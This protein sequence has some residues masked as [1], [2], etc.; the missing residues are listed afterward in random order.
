MTYPQDRHQKARNKTLLRGVLL[1]TPSDSSDDWLTSYADLVTLLM[2]FF[3]LLVSISAIDASKYE[4]IAKSFSAGSEVHPPQ[5]NLNELY[6]ELTMMLREENLTGRVEAKK[7]PTGIA[8]SVPGAYLFGSGSAEISEH[9][10]PLIRR[11]ADIIRAVPYQIAIEGHTDDVPIH[12]REFPSNW[13]LSAARASRIVRFMIDHGVDSRRLRATGF[14][15]TRPVAPNID[16][17]TGEA[18]EPNRAR[19]RRVVI[20]FLAF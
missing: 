17:K 5:K 19:N 12:S 20:R 9:A 4:Q 11:L 3:V 13:E 7:T 10:L 18:S 14:A 6:R 2:T 15:D 16:P 8:I 1:K